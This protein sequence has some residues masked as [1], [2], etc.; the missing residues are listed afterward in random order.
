MIGRGFIAFAFLFASASAFASHESR[1]ITMTTTVYSGAGTSYASLGTAG[2]GQQYVVASVSGSWVQIWWAGNRGWVPAS[3]TTIASGTGG[4]VIYSSVAVRSGPAYT[5][6]AVGYAHSGEIYVVTGASGS[7]EQIWFGGAQQWIYGAYTATHTLSGSTTTTPPPST[8]GSTWNDMTYSNGHPLRSPSTDSNILA[9]EKE[10]FDLVNNHR[11][12]I[13]RNALVYHTRLAEIARANSRH[14]PIH[15]YT[16]HLNPE[17]DHSWDRI[18]K[19]GVTTSMSGENIS[20]GYSS[21]TSAFN[22]W[23]NSPTH[24]SNLESSNWTHTGVGW[25]YQS[26]SRWG[27]YRT[28]LFVRNPSN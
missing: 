11:V 25:W 19:G 18:R 12:S 17:G 4:Q 20:W 5:Y 16:A 22:G 24:R 9:K 21:N 10:I 13:G 6:T 7:Y 8:G 2:A 27:T 28:Q 3:A 26:G 1:K 23:L 15:N 14:M